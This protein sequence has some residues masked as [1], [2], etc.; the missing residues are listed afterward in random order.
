M[1]KKPW[2]EYT[3]PNHVEPQDT[4]VSEEK[5]PW[6]EFAQEGAIP[7][8]KKDESVVEG[9]GTN[10]S[11]QPAKPSEKSTERPSNL[12]R[13]QKFAQIEY[14]EY[15]NKLY[16]KFQ[17]ELPENPTE[18]E[19]RK[20]NEDF[21]N[22]IRAKEKELN[23][24][25]VKFGGL[26]QKRDQ[27]K[28]K[29]E[30]ALKNK[31]SVT[32]TLARLS[33]YGIFE[34][35]GRSALGTLKDQVPAELRSEDLRLSGGTMESMLMPRNNIKS[36]GFESKV[37]TPELQAEF[38][39]WNNKEAQG[40]TVGE[41]IKT[42]LKKKFGEKYSQ[43]EQEFKAEQGKYR[44]GIEKE[45][46]EQN[47]EYQKIIKDAP[48]DIGD[49]TPENVDKFIG[50]LAG[51][52]F[53]RIIPSLLTA[54]GSSIVA[55]RSAV[56][57]EQLDKAS[58]K[59]GL[60][61]EEIVSKGLDNPE[62]G[63]VLADFLALTDIASVGNIAAGAGKKILRKAVGVAGEAAQEAIQGE[64]EAY[65]GAKG[66]GVDYEFKPNR[67]ITGA[68]G[69][70]IGSAAVSSV[71]PGESIPE[72]AKAQNQT[73]LN[74]QRNIDPANPAS[75]D[76]AAAAIEQEV[77]KPVAHEEIKTEPVVTTDPGLVLPENKEEETNAVQKQTEE[78]T[79][80]SQI[81]EPSDDEFKAIKQ[82]IVD[83]LDKRLE[84]T[85]MNWERNGIIKIKCD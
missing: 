19:S 18:E 45:I 2:K 66:A 55:E 13:I 41:N 47:K 43:K 6:E 67:A 50:S 35:A 7:L 31:P 84:A 16:S 82:N 81:T 32:S 20:A 79:Q 25:V 30:A 52:G 46:Q 58:E 33:G 12:Q 37:I 3:S 59:T 56:F 24:V 70:L 72:K 51:Q 65:G 40:A 75:L 36:T 69:G 71:I 34:Y 22:A 53:G 61:R 17:D 44:T 11:L 1:P 38:R 9:P 5:K 26:Y 49:V 14:D 15:V 63:R 60:S 85:L 48:Q 39:R 73:I 76:Q 28:S 62:S 74:I 68:L 54:G 42:F 8:K 83:N 10:A 80:E 57:N 77:N 23:D 4:A 64:G 27:H 21:G 78:P 29:Q